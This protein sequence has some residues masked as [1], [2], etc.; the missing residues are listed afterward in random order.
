[1]HDINPSRALGLLGAL[2][3]RDVPKSVR[4]S[5]MASRCCAVLWLLWIPALFVEHALRVSWAAGV[6][7]PP[8]GDVVWLAVKVAGPVVIVA[9]A[10]LRVTTKGTLAQL[11]LAKVCLE[12]KYPMVSGDTLHARCPECGT[13]RQVCD[14]PALQHQV[15]RGARTISSLIVLVGLGV[16]ATAAFVVNMLA[17]QGKPLFLSPTQ[18]TQNTVF[19]LLL[20]AIF[21]TT[22]FDTLVETGIAARSDA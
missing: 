22:I 8:F 5:V 9:V 18:E 4:V 1:M 6:S 11:S 3:G 12:C 14:F 21:A 17:S 13:P 2:L 15:K 16:L 10:I 19:Y 7:A 20:A